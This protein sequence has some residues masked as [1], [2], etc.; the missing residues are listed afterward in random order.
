MSS[1]HFWFW[2]Y[3]RTVF[4]IPSSNCR[5]GCQSSSRLSLRESMA[6]LRSWPARSVTYVM[7]Y[8]DD[9]S[10]LPSSLSTVL[11]ITRIRSMFFHSLKP[12][13]LYVSATLPLWKITSMARA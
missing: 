9:P 2:R 1:I 11:T 12:P 4:S 7:S 5:L 8:S 6:Y 10:G 13:M 3:Q